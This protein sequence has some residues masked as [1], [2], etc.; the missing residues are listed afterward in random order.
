M[1]ELLSVLGF[2][3]YP[4]ALLTLVGLGV[5]HGIYTGLKFVEWENSPEQVAIR[6]KEAYETAHAYLKGKCCCGRDKT[7][8]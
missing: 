1:N 6:E 7:Q 5:W 2:W 4:L 3:G 8:D